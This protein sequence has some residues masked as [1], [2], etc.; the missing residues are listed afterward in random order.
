MNL[1]ALSVKQPFAWLLV[2]GWKDIEYRTWRTNHRGRLLIHAGKKI[3]K[4]SMADLE[5][6]F[7]NVEKC[8]PPESLYWTGGIIGQV[9]LIDCIYSPSEQD[10]E[11]RVITPEPCKLIPLAGKLYLFDVDSKLVD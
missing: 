2:N 1:K 6:Y 11:W 8:K 9:E 4:E 3:D 10:Y 5:A 7:K